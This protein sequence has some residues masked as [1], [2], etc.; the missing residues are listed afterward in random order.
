[1]RGWRWSSWFSQCLRTRTLRALALPGAP[2]SQSLS[3][4]PKRADVFSSRSLPSERVGSRSGGI[5]LH[6]SL[7]HTS[8]GFIP[9]HI[10]NLQR[11]NA[12]LDK[13]VV[14]DQCPER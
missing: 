14:A 8:A 3:F 6:A 13:G 10:F 4:R 11:C 12:L 1:M 2:P 5:S 7:W 9:G